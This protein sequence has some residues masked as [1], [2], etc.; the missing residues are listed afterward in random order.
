MFDLKEHFI[1]HVGQD[2]RAF[3]R[4]KETSGTLR[5]VWESSQKNSAN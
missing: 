2:R 5:L 1:G 4:T 3:F